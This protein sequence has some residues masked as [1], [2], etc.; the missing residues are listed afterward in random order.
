MWSPLYSR[1]DISD[2][3]T[4]SEDDNQNG[5]DLKKRLTFMARR[6]TGVGRNV[7]APNDL[8]KTQESADKSADKSVDNQEDKG[9]AAFAS[10]SNM[11]L[12]RAKDYVNFIVKDVAMPDKPEQDNVDRRTTPRM[13]W[14]DVSVAV[15]GQAAQDVAR[16]FIQRYVQFKSIPYS[17]C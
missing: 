11:T 6:L 1:S 13:P 2:T 8:T 7:V 16:H 4:D 14:H 9:D 17:L 12:W 15:K 5:T 3:D 10:Y